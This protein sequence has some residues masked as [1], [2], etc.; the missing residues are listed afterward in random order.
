M[1]PDTAL[2]TGDAAMEPDT[3][4]ET[5]DAAMEPDTALE[6]GD[7]AME[8]DTALETG[9]AAMEPDTAPQTKDAAM[10]PDT[11]PQ[12]KDAAPPPDPALQPTSE[13]NHPDWVGVLVKEMGQVLKEHT[14]LVVASLASSAPAGGKP[15]PCPEEGESEGAAV[16]PTDITTVQVP[17]E[18]Q[19]QSQPAAVAPVE[20]KKSK[21]KLVLNSGN[22][23]KNGGP[24]QSTEEPQV[25]I[26]TESLSYESL[27]NLQKDI[28]RQGRE[29]YTTWL[30]WVW[31]LM[32]RGVQ[33]DGAEARNL[34]PLTQD[35]GVNQVFVREQGP[36]HLWERLLMSVRGR[37]IHRDRIQEHHHR[38]CWKNLR[39]GSNS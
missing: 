28:T 21:A 26:I 27:C 31:D 1:E 36:L 23:V 22:K 2:E 5:G 38:M 6:T 12:T 8:P 3:A 37:F 14:T 24:T 33:L 15:S 29:P 34:G 17:A 13:M 32:G 35:S 4:L 30:L 19:G 18:A 9:D 10:E 7:A 20:R 39:K 25:E 16:E 11:A